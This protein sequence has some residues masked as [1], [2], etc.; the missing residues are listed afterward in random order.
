M[1][2]RMFCELYSTTSFLMESM[3]VRR[4]ETPS[5]RLALSCTRPSRIKRAGSKK[6]KRK[7]TKKLE[8]SKRRRKKK[9]GRR[10]IGFLS[11]SLSLRWHCCTL[12]GVCTIYSTLCWPTAG[13]KTAVSWVPP[14]ALLLPK[15]DP[16]VCG[17]AQSLPRYWVARYSASPWTSERR[18]LYVWLPFRHHQILTDWTHT[19]A[20]TQT[21]VSW[22]FVYLSVDWYKLIAT[23]FT[24][25]F[26]LFETA[27]G[28]YRSVSSVF[29]LNERR[30][31]GNICRTLFVSGQY[32]A[33][34]PVLLPL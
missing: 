33:F 23:S 7:T 6:T 21:F 10:R 17:G 4:S 31:S 3:I 1:R 29:C 16:L 25:E 22:T 24:I 27:S 30:S 2:K 28:S 13:R 14:A 18:P 19:H 26:G 5:R 34:P 32:R 20:H 11:F 9:K 12:Y 15:R 8:G